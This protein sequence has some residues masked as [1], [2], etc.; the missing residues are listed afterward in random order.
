MFF[1]EQIN[2]V[3]SALWCFWRYSC[4]FEYNVKLIGLGRYIKIFRACPALTC[5]SVCT[6]SELARV[7][8]RVDGLP[9]PGACVGAPDLAGC[10]LHTPHYV[11]RGTHTS[12]HLALVW[13]VSRDTPRLRRVPSMSRDDAVA[14]ILRVLY[15]DCYHW[16]GYRKPKK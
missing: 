2:S 14:N 3:R 5:G 15:C 6:R 7:T 16:Y 1:Y 11:H 8:S 13:C 4:V 9:G 12:L 10:T